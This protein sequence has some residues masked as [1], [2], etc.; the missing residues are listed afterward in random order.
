MSEVEMENTSEM[1]AS[2]TE[3]HYTQTSVGGAFPAQLLHCSCYAGSNNQTE[4]GDTDRPREASCAGREVI[5]P[6]APIVFV[7]CH[8]RCICGPSIKV[9]QVPLAL[10]FRQVWR[11]HREVD[12]AMPIEL[13][14]PRMLLDVVYA[15][16]FQGQA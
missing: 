7:F 5:V 11:L 15:S 16:D 14:E 12:H 6:T 1:A 4:S 3:C 9:P 10:H 13:L 2:K 8:R